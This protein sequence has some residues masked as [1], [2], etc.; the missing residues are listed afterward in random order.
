VNGKEFI[1]KA[2]RWA[3]LN[4]LAAFVDASRGKG[5]HQLLTIGSKWTTVP[6]GEIPPGT[7]HALLK[8]LGI[9]KGEF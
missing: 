6:S 4:G 5:G 8:Q 3:K 9:P 2:T 1:R 7:F